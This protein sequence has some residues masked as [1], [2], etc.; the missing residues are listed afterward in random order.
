V[1][2]LFPKLWEDRGLQEIRLGEL[3][4]KASEKL[5]RAVLG[6]AV[7]P[8]TIALLTER[9]AGNAFYLEELIRAAAEGKHDE[10]PD[11]VLA[12]V[13]AR[14]AALAP[15]ARRVLRAAALFGQVF[16]E[17]GVRALLGDEASSLGEWLDVLAGEELIEARTR[18]R[19][20][21]AGGDEYVFRQALVREAAYAM[22]TESDRALGHV[23]AGQWL[24]QAGE[25]D[26][27]VLAEHFE[28]GGK[29]ARAIASYRRAAEQALEGN[30][31]AAVITRA[32]KA[33]ACGASGETLG[34][35][36]L[37]AAEACSWRGELRATLTS[38]IEAMKHL[39]KG[40]ARWYAAAEF[41]GTASGKLGDPRI[42]ITIAEDLCAAPP[43]DSSS[44]SAA[45][46]AF[47]SVAARVITRLV[48]ATRIDM[49]DR[50]LERLRQGGADQDVAT[51]DPVAF[52][53]LCRAVAARA[54]SAGDLGTYVERSELAVKSFERAGDLRSVC[55]QRT[56]L[57][58]AY[59]EIGLHE[60]AERELR[61]GI[62]GADRMGLS[63]VSA[64]GRQNLS[65]TL[66]RVGTL[67][68]A[69]ALAQSSAETFAAQGNRRMEA[70]SRAYLADILSLTDHL[71]AEQE[72]RRAVVAASSAP[73]ARIRA[74]GILA[75]ILVRKGSPDEA[76]QYAEEGMALLAS[77]DGV[78]EDNSLLQLAHAQALHA[79][80]RVEDAKAA[81]GQARRRV[82]A[83]AASLKNAAWRASFL[84]RVPENKWTL[85]LA[86]AW[87]GDGGG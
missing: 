64:Q 39:E 52:A 82:M 37:L 1:C 87:H 12:M 86:R 18:G 84:E 69:A 25:T 81:I 72:A 74:L 7:L 55:G 73:V 68:E 60:Q 54:K 40:T 56:T 79:T 57:G 26:A 11:T 59:L 22:L 21:G 29:P 4:R 3:T 46:T 51:L 76:L 34:A 70:A 5:V 50:L 41:A 80:G 49:A 32:D 38:S 6:D 42:L 8:K 20:P 71:A 16:W 35:L 44:S 2:D 63:I 17:G 28:R 66:A 31:L 58:Y 47:V 10:L 27:M 43:G 85:A 33:I 48:L 24:E 23:L 13:E 9:A 61:E 62:A 15:E 83:K 78:D 19:F 67:D 65:I 14:L 30:D 36:R 77:L 53:R 75:H 45:D